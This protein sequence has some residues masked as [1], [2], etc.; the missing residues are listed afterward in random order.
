LLRAIPRTLSPTDGGR[1]RSRNRVGAVRCRARKDNIFACCVLDS[2]C[3]GFWYRKISRQYCSVFT[4]HPY[5]TKNN[6][7]S[8]LYRPSSFGKRSLV[9]CF[10]Y[11]HSPIDRRGARAKSVCV[12]VDCSI[13]SSV[14]IQTVKSSIS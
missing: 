7:V 9:A 14:A 3:Y 11:C 6:S 1:S 5:Q 12:S 4:G 10:R 8:G 13:N 2:S